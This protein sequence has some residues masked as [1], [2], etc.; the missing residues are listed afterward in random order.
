MLDKELCVYDS[1]STLCLR[2]DAPVTSVVAWESVCVC[3]WT[4]SVS[5]S[6]LVRVISGV[7]T[8]LLCLLR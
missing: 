7:A 3:V 5:T 6:L 8:L 2:E 4:V 1:V